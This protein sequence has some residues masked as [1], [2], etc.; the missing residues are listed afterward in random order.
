MSEEEIVQQDAVAEEAPVT[1]EPEQEVSTEEQ[2]ATPEASEEPK[3]RRNRAEE[4]IHAL[5][6]EKYDAQRQTQA[7]QQQIAELQQY[8]QQQQQPTVVDDIPKLQDFDYDEN[9]Y[10]QALAQWSQSQRTQWEKEQ[11]EREQQAAMQQKA[12]QR[13]ATLQQTVAKGVE[14]YP[15]FALKVFDRNLPSLADVS[16][17]A[18]EAMMDSEAGADIAY[19]LASNPQEVYA[20]DGIS[21]TQAIRKMVQL[22]AKFQKKQA[23]NVPPPPPSRVS[24]N[25]EAAENLQD[26]STAEWIERRNRQLSKR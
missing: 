17:V 2:S 13:Q 5:T 10:Q 1:E 15:D 3:P 9:K 21:P 12:M 22:E 19:H 16:P 8:V 4:R 20:F 24:G 25:S 11:Q 23:P 26:L 6:K 18:F 7:L 14:K